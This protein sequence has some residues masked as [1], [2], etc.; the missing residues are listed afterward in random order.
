M[1]DARQTGRKVKC[2]KWLRFMIA[3]CVGALLLVGC[4]E[5]TSTDAGDEASPGS[6]ATDVTEEPPAVD[7]TSA[8]A[9]SRTPASR[10]TQD[11]GAA[12]AR[13]TNV[14]LN[15]TG[16]LDDDEPAEDVQ[17]PSAVQRGDGEVP[18]DLLETI[19]DDAAGRAGVSPAEV[20]VVQARAVVWSDA[21]L[22]CPQPGMFYTQALV[23]GYH[24]IL[25]AGGQTFDYRVGSNNYFTL[26]TN[27]PAEGEPGAD[28]PARMPQP[29]IEP[30][31]STPGRPMQVP[32][33]P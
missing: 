10:G 9:P 7:E 21:S 23:S 33:E 25:S 14:P 29:G 17:P 27:P 3:A 31:E 15:P 8:P 24:V 6:P 26:C 32:L 1:Q 13:P 28:P 4:M 18:A 30:P 11:E 20:E 16:V 12:T 2:M 5:P 19:I 22:G